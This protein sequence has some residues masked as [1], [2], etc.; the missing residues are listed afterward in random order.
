M[1]DPV[2]GRGGEVRVPEHGAPL[3]QLHVRRD[4]HAPGLVRRRH[5]LV[6]QPRALDVDRYVA[7]LVDDQQ[8]RLRDVLER[9]LQPAVG[10]RGLEHQHQ[11]RRLDGAHLVAALRR[12]DPQRDRQMGLPPAAAA[13]EHEVLGGFD[14]AERPH[15]VDRVAVG[16][17][18]LAE[19]EVRER[20]QRRKPRLAQEPRLFILL[21]GRVLAPDQVAHGDELAA[22]RLLG[23]RRD[24]RPAEVHRARKRRE[25]GFQLPAG[26]LLRV[27]HAPLPNTAS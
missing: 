3:P 26:Q 8:V 9:R 4:D 25:L 21:P 13:V 27:H 12:E 18:H 17:G 23:E 5:D 2:D 10:G 19:V 16:H 7:I 20:L 1:H 6:E 24:G 15:V 22:R 14:E 11:R